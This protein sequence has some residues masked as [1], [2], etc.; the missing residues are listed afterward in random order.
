MTFHGCM[1]TKLGD[2]HLA[3]VGA[4]GGGYSHP[5]QALGVFP[6]NILE[7]YMATDACSAYLHCGPYKINIRV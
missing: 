4:G 2:A 3:G 1:Q 6:K 5:Q 7:N